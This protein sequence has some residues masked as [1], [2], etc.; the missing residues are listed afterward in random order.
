MRK[1]PLT[2]LA[3]RAAWLAPPKYIWHLARK[4]LVV[5]LLMLSVLTLTVVTATAED[6]A[7]LIGISDYKDS[8]G[9]TDLRGPSNDVQLLSTVL[10]ERGVTDIRI[11]ADG[12]PDA[13]RPTRDAI[14]SAFADMAQVSDAGDLVFVHISGHGTRQPDD[15][16]DE[17]DGYDEVLLP[18]DAD[19][20]PAGA[21]FIPN[22]ITDDEIGEALAAIRARGADVFLVADTCHSGTIARDAS[23]VAAAR[24]VDPL[25][26]GVPNVTGF[27]LAP[28]GL[29]GRGTSTDDLPGRLVALYAAQSTELSMEFDFNALSG[30]NADTAT[31][32]D[33]GWYGFFTSKLAER[34]RT[35]GGVS[36]RQL[37]QA[38]LSDM[39]T[40]S[41]PIAGTRQT[42][43]WEAEGGLFDDAVFGAS[44]RTLV[45]QFT[46]EETKLS[47][48][49]VQG[50]DVGTVLEVV[51]DAA[52]DTVIGHVQ[53]ASALALT[54]RVQAVG[55]ECTPVEGALCAII[56]TDT[57]LRGF[58]RPVAQP[59]SLSLRLSE[60]MILGTSDEDQ[61]STVNDQLLTALDEALAKP[62]EVLG[63]RFTVNSATF[64][65]A[66]GVAKGRL[67]FGPQVE[68]G[69]E[70]I[71]VNWGPGDA[72]SLD[73]VLSRIAYAE[74]WRRIASG[75]QAEASIL[76]SN[77]IATEVLLQPSRVDL[78][79]DLDGDLNPLVECG[80]IVNERGLLEPRALR[81]GGQ[82]KQCDQIYPIVRSSGGAY[83]VNLLL[84]DTSA[85]VHALHERYD[86]PVQRRLF[87]Q[88]P[89]TK[90]SDCGNGQQNTGQETLI[91]LVTES[92]QN[93]DQLNLAG[94][95]DNCSAAGTRGDASSLAGSPLGGLLSD[96]MQPAGGTRGQLSL[97]MPAGVW[98]ERLDWVVVPRT[99]AKQNLIISTIQSNQ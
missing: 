87:G 30:N 62:A 44:G 26:L 29:D 78:L 28:E 3:R 49:L 12:V 8:S 37:F 90:C 51:A 23:T 34:L 42:P 4:L 5:S 21:R 54:S 20:V 18:S 33:T 38:I 1:L 65:L 41:L 72:V 32:S 93:A 7:L 81:A 73:T 46:L 36:Y 82:V 31:A 75:I 25:A 89:L 76:F 19:K 48:G 83:D 22:A 15:D 9:I 24:F 66:V 53:V 59:V 39:N 35:V 45:R 27:S 55:E 64:D 11:L 91:L 92:K 67:W 47:G 95:A 74:R 84:I 56:E 13:I 50:L 63:G 6:R 17:A 80:T 99:L 98:V 14:L 88:A 2:G 86:G 94:L 58:A 70:P 79:A 52:S 85:C 60:P 71:G 77:P 68:L 96:I 69:S 57:P 97:S 16:G 10:A 40:A 61:S 43:Y